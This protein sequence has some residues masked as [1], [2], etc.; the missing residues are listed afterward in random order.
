MSTSSTQIFLRQ[1]LMAVWGIVTLVL[2]FCVLLLVNEMMKAGKEPLKIPEASGTASI[3]KQTP[4]GPVGLGSREAL[5]Y[6]GDPNGSLLLPEPVRIERSET[7]VENCRQLLDALIRGPRDILVPVIP[8]STKIRALYLLPGGELV[9]DFSRELEV[10]SRKSASAEAMMVYSVVGTLSQPA[11]KG[12]KDEPVTRV[13]FLIEG[14]APQ[15]RFPAHLDL[16]A[17]VSPN[18]EWFASAGLERR[19][20]A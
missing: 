8:T 15:E 4:T 6:F 19:G 10:D 12:V 3:N 17:P 9:V 1:A 13:R 2:I 5:A 11:A 18:P 14:S 16:S 20:N 7:T